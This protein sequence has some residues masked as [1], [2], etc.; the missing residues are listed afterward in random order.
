MK[1]KKFKS[2]ISKKWIAEK[3]HW[4]KI[5][6]T[7][8]VCNGEPFCDKPIGYPEKQIKERV[9]EAIKR[10]KIGID[11]FDDDRSHKKKFGR[12]K[13]SV[14]NVCDMKVTNHYAPRAAK[15]IQGN[16][17]WIV[18]HP[19]GDRQFLQLINIGECQSYV[20]NGTCAQ[21]QWGFSSLDT[22]CQ[23]EYTE[24]KLVAVLSEDGQVGDAM[25][26]IF[27]FPSCCTCQMKDLASDYE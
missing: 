4:N 25:V 14:Q 13:R 22:F 27:R 23:Q 12:L 20:V 21:G 15:N 10:G 9:V 18:N 19:Q 11:Q 16:P 5:F 8:E 26:D 24:H 6:A 1:R 17:R 3:N 7:E 2:P